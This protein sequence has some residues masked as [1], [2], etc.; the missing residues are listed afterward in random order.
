[1]LCSNH[2]SFL[3]GFVVFSSLPFHNIEDVFFLGYSDI[4]G[5]PLA[6][7]ELKEARLISID[8]NVNL[9][10]AMQA[11][12][13]VFSRGKVVCL[14]PEGR[15]SIDEN[16]GEFKKGMG[17][18]IK[19]L[20]IPVVS[21]YIKGSH[22]S[23]PRASRLPRFCPLKVIFGRPLAAKDLL[24]KKEPGQDDYEAIANNLR[25]EVLK[26]AC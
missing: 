5:H 24:G 8:S 14:F 17:I 16:I 12:S 11:A 13:L 26:L 3:D 22:R 1:L 2:A 7:W 21:I 6:R 9:T 19:E 20:D 18:L 10:E 23:W 15:R 4:L 25:E